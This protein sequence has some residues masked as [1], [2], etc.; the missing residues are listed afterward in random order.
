MWSSEASRGRK[1]LLGSLGSKTRYYSSFCGW[2]VAND[3]VAVAWASSFDCVMYIARD[4]LS[5]ILKIDRVVKRWGATEGVH[6][7]FMK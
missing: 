4:A 5:Y 1:K 7:L 2:F 6:G 3:G